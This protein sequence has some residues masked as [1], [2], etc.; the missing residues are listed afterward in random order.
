MGT[1]VALGVQIHIG[2]GGQRRLFA[3]IDESVLAVGEMDGGE[4]AAA[5]IAAEGWTTAIA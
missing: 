3:E 5:D 1:H 2:A 4:A